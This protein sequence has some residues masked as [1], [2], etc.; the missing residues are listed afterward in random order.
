MIPEQ[1]LQFGGKRRL[2]APQLPKPGGSVALIEFERPVEP[3]TE[4]LP[5]SGIDHGHRLKLRGTR[6]SR[7]QDMPVGETGGLIG[8]LVRW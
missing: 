8:E 1:L 4:L 3:R 2:L 7:T 6:K 5:A